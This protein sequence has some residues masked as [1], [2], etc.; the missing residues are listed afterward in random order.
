MFHE[1]ERRLVEGTK[2][3]RSELKGAGIKGERERVKEQNG[4]LLVTVS[5]GTGNTNH[6]KDRRASSY[7]RWTERQIKQ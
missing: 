6:C 7:S 1:C 2:C 5:C 3:K 4:R